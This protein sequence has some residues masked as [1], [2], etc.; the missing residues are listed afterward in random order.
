M[1]LKWDETGKKTWEA[2]VEKGVLY[3]QDETGAYPA[4]VAWN[5]LTGVS[6][7]PS[8]AEPTPFYADNTKYASPLS[9][10]EFA[11]T[12]EAFTYPAEFTKCDGSGE[13]AVGVYVGQ[14]AR[15]PFG[16]CYRSSIGNDLEDDSYGYILHLIYGAKA[17]PSEKPYKTVNGTPEL[18]AF[19]WGVT[20]TPVS[21]PGLKPTASLSIN[22]TTVDPTELAALEAILYG[23]ETIPA[24]LPLPTEI[25]TLFAV[26][27]G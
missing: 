3:V 26:A 4:G 22:S 10:E 24:R 5:G 25:K 23:T 27:E 18:M 15:K 2:G 14:Q 8:G 13:I 7:S 11:A 16:L 17:A 21:V 12:I 1:Q 6:E 9:V 19:S 20:T